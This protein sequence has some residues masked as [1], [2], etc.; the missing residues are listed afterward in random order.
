[1]KKNNKAFT[2][3]ELL[4]IITITWIIALWI[5]NMSIGR[6]ADAQKIWIFQ[7]KIR[8]NIE[9]AI[10]YSLIWKAIDSNMAVPKFWKININSDNNWSWT[11]SVN[12]SFWS[13]TY[14]SYKWLTIISPN[15]YSISNIKCRDIKNT[16]STNISDNI[17]LFIE[18]WNVSIPW[19][20][21][22]KKV[23]E[24]EMKYKNFKKIISINS[25][26]NVIN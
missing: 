21:A 11:W 8:S 9:T 24:F 7:N 19:C 15:Y 5:N 20:P 4:I 13:W 22:D 18:N 10:N 3:L 14:Q 6:I 23:L 17:D 1:M 2:L 25:V 16:S 12:V 26:N